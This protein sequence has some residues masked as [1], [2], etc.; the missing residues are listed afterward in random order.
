MQTVTTWVPCTQHVW[1][2]QQQIDQAVY[3]TCERCPEG[4]RTDTA[5][6]E[7]LLRQNVLAS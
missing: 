7:S 6:A 2:V 1:H 5:G 3:L 4:R